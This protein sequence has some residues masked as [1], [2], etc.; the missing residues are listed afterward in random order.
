MI[1][2]SRLAAAAFVLASALAACGPGDKEKAA[3]HVKAGT[4]LAAQGKHEDAIAEFK[5]A[6]DM[7]RDSLD[8]RMG[9]GDSYRAL[10]KYDD[11][12]AAYDAAKK[13]DRSSP[14]PHLAAAYA[15]LE[16]GEIDKAIAEA[17]Q[18]TEVDPGNLEGMILQGRVSMMPRKLP[19]GS[20]GVPQ[21]SLDRAKLNLEAAVQNAPDNVEARYWLAKLYETL[22][23]PEQALTAWT[24]VG[25]LAAG[26]PQHARM[27]PEIAEAIS[28][29]KR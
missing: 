8:A 11:A 24:K 6:A 13:V 3:A 1:R 29:L 20:T 18:A 26:K 17:D 21:A 7:N 12:F 19:D 15:R 10:K 16:R 2:F 27:A 14:R 25:E 23:M 5:K 22:K 9:L 4:E 28:R